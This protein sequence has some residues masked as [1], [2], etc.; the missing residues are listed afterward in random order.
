MAPGKIDTDGIRNLILDLG[1]VILELDVDATIRAFTQ[2]GFPP[3]KSADIILSKYP[4]FLDFE[5]GIISPDV[6]LGKVLEIS[7]NSV[8]REEILE[9]WNSMILGLLS[10]TYPV[11]PV[12]NFPG[13][14]M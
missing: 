2:L 11:P 7:G 10:Y 6:F 14:E 8:S 1:G 3:L 12:F 13:F 4:F 5:T 9:A